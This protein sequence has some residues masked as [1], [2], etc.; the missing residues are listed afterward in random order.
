MAIFIVLATATEVTVESRKMLWISGR[1]PNKRMQPTH[2][3]VIKICM[4]KFV[5]CLADG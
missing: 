4:R 2:Q 1:A 5:A 3:P